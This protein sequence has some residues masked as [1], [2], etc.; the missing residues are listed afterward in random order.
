MGFKLYQLLLPVL[1]LLIVFVLGWYQKRR[2]PAHSKLKLVVSNE[3]VAT[4]S[5][6]K[7]TAFER[8][9][10]AVKSPPRRNDENR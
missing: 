6:P 1:F 7:N 9:L 5:T 8:H 4:E 3:R 10:E 2:K